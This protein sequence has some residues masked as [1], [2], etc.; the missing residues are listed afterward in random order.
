[1]TKEWSS[2][3]IT[4]VLY[5]LVLILPLS[6]YFVYSSFKTIQSDTKIL[7]QIGWTGG[8]IES[9]ALN[10][11]DQNAQKKIQQIDS[12]FQEMSNWIIKNDTSDLYVGADSLSQDFLQMKTCWNE[13]KLIINDSSAISNNNKVLK[14]WENSSYLATMIE[15]MVYLK[16]KKMI[17]IFYF[18]L[19][20]AMILI[21]VIIYM[22]RTYVHI[23]M[24]K[25]AIIDVET[26]LFNQKY[27][28]AEFKSTLARAVRHEYALSILKV[29]I[30]GFEKGSKQYDKNTKLNTLKAFGSLIHSLVRDGD[31]PARYDDNHFLILLP[32][33]DKENA[34]LFEKRIRES[35]MKDE[36]LI[37][38]KI[39]LEFNI[40][41]FDRVE[42]GEAFI[43]R[44]LAV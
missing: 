33:T 19:T 40:T 24:K 42:T 35:I 28:L 26:T 15:K 6:F 29:K 23:Q 21:L 13:Y 25:N 11:S 43:Q 1:M 44:T 20:I 14:C 18:S 39:N 7:Y 31:L 8:T 22:V 3:R 5:L 2:F 27:F 38:E 10:P 4:L 30:D 12:I 36:C 17:N 32:Y 41:E 37:S 34:E 9:L 16:Q